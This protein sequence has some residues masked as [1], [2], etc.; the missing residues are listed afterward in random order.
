MRTSL[1]EFAVGVMAGGIVAWLWG[2]QI[3]D[4]ADTHTRDIRERAADGLR[5]VQETADGALEGARGRIHSTLEAGRDAVR[6]GAMRV[7][8]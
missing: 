2:R 8:S 4:Y 5:S 3:Q 6:P 7:G 1:T